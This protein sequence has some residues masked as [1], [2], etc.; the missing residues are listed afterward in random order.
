MTIY[1]TGDDA[2]D[3][4]LTEDELALLIGMLLD[5]QVPMETAFAGPPRSANASA[6]STPRR[7][8]NYDP[9][10]F[11]EVFKQPPAVHRFPGSMAARVQALCAAIEDDWDGDAAAIWTR[12][13][14]G[15]RRGAAP[16]E[17]A[18]RIRR[19]EGQ[20]SS[21]RCSASSAA[22]TRRRLAGGIRTYGESRLA[23]RRWPT[24]STPTRWL[25]CGR[26]RRRRSRRGQV[27]LGGTV[28]SADAFYGCT[29]RGEGTMTNTT[30]P[31]SWPGDASGERSN[32]SGASRRYLH[33]R[34]LLRAVKSPTPRTATTA[35]TPNPSRSSSTPSRFPTATCWSSSSRS[36]IRRRRTGKATTSGPATV[37]RSSTPAKRRSG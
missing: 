11:V 25:R 27:A 5:Q 32:S 33:A 14:A 4:L 26:Q 36:T 8:P 2:A 28:R 17:G 34:W 15:R 6:R 22:S 9:D 30:T 18:A 12:R 13:R 23:D 24:S 29:D 37:R 3:A 19:A 21:S 35:T 7:S 16:A 31:R 10:A 1:L 20:A